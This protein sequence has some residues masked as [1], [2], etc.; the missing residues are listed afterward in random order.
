MEF[1]KVGIIGAGNIG[2]GVATDL[3][4]HGIET[5]LVDVSEKQLENAKS[6]IL[7]NIRFA[8]LFLKNSPRI[9]YP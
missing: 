6:E 7:K 5:V 9:I 3:I 2:I 4:L 1:K 8:P